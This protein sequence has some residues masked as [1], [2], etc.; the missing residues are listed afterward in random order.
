MAQQVYSKDLNYWGGGDVA[1]YHSDCVPNIL[2]ASAECI[3]LDV[4]LP[5]LKAPM[6]NL[7]HSKWFGLGKKHPKTPCCYFTYRPMTLNS[8]ILSL[9]SRRS[10]HNSQVSARYTCLCMGRTRIGRKAFCLNL[11]HVVLTALSLRTILL[12]PV[13]RA[14]KGLT[15]R[16]MYSSSL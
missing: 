6:C 5:A 14:S 13:R 2:K 16:L 10:P 4:Y 9:K 7:G 15:T 11:N 8:R 12:C 3:S 1:G